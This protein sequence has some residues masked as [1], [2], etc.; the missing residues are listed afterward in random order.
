MA[1]WKIKLDGEHI[2]APE[3]FVDDIDFLE[4]GLTEIN[5]NIKA[6]KAPT[7][8][9]T[10]EIF[11]DGD[12]ADIEIINDYSCDY[13]KKQRDILDNIINTIESKDK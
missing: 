2:L 10:F 7:I 4:L 5:F 1:K 3:V 11:N 9:T 6:H 12:V 8:T 13:L